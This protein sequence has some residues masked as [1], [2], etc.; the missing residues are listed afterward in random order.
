[1][2]KSLLALAVSGLAIVGNPAFAAG[3]YII[4]QVGKSDI[5]AGEG[6][7]GGTFDDDS[8]FFSLGVGYRVTENIAF[9]L[10]YNNFGEAEYRYSEADAFYDLNGK[11]TL[12]LDA[13][14]VAAVGILPLSPSFQLFG[15]I[16]LDLW[17]A[18]WKDR[19]TGMDADGDFSGSDK[20]SDDGADLFYSVGAAFNVSSNTDIFVEYQIHEFELK[21]TA[22]EDFDID[23]D[24]DVDVLSVGINYSF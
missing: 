3:P 20:L 9:E 24:I 19:F 15:K 12:E 21:D 6:S 13:V 8:A 16:G 23:Y 5:D 2:K 18:E 14:S 22:Y 17:D 1:M 10:S 7:A 4:G 11:E